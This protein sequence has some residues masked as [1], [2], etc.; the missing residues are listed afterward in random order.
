MDNVTGRNRRSRA[1]TGLAATTINITRA[2]REIA[3]RY[4]FFCFKK[5]RRYYPERGNRSE[6][7]DVAYLLRPGGRPIFW[8]EIDN[9][10]TRAA[11][12][13][14]K[15]FGYPH[16][17]IPITAL[18]IHHGHV[19]ED[20]LAY[21]GEILGD[22]ALPPRFLDS[23]SIS[24]ESYDLI[25]AQLGRWI[26]GV[27]SHLAT[28]PEWGTVLDVSSQYQVLVSSGGL[29]LAA[30]HLETQAELA[31]SLSQNGIVDV[32]RAACLTITLARML[33]RAG[34]HESA[35]KQMA[36]IE[37]RV[38]RASA[39]GGA[40]TS[41]A[42]AVTFMLGKTSRSD[43]F[44]A[45]H[46]QDALDSVDQ[47]Y[48][49]SQFL[50]RSAIPHIISGDRK[51]VDR[52][53]MKYR[54]LLSDSTAAQSNSALLRGLDALKWKRGD[55]RELA[56]KH[57]RYE[58]FLLETQGGPPEGTIHGF[59][60]ALYL[61]VAAEVA[62]G[63]KETSALLAEIDTF[64]LHAGIPPTA[65]GLREIRY[66][67]PSMIANRPAEVGRDDTVSLW[68]QTSRQLQRRLNTLYAKVEFICGR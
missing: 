56:A 38:P 42:N 6:R 25:L 4:Y 23:L 58:H 21:P 13:R 53:I 12:N 51:Q 1:A 46:L 29:H 3:G 30:A 49:K 47:V 60:A 17:L 41:A 20:R 33:Q 59:V 19:G 67:L 11:Y 48:N 57:S 64:C 36:Q 52:I 10:P 63:T 68:P 40:T 31:W 37:K 9:D 7:I 66:V 26:Q 27:I 61:K 39:L 5:E 24:T 18:A 45:G 34:Y 15:I 8:F 62:Y 14:F 65:D 32:E 28:A 22:A 55:W 50:W 54:D 43:V 44:S 2:L 35:R 16:R